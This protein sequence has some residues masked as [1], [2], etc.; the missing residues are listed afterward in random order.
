M[1]H[2]L[3]RT[4]RAMRM[5]CARA[6]T[7]PLRLSVSEDQTSI[8]A[9]NAMISLEVWAFSKKIVIRQTMGCALNPLMEE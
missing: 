2:E 6:R 5:R 1:L 4:I 3:D 9:G 8:T 7:P